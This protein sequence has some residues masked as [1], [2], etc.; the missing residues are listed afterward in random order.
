[1]KMHVLPGDSLIET[2]KKINIEGEIIVCRECLVDGDLSA[3]NL[4]DFW[5]VRENYL[6][7]E[8]GETRK[9]DGF[10]S[11]SVKGEFEKLL[12][13]P[14]KAEINLWFEYELFCQVNM[15]FCLSLLQDSDTE[16]YRV[17]P[18]LRNSEDLWKGFGGLSESDLQKCFDVRKK[19]SY[20]DL[21]LGA[22]LWKAFQD[23]D[24]NELQKLS[25]TE[26]EC[27][28]YLEEVCEAAIEKENRPKETVQKIMADGESDF[29]K[30]L[31]KFNETEGVYGFGDLQVKK[32]YD[33]CQNRLR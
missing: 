21:K 8:Y 31:R 10:Y 14:P 19:L 27:S 22:N 30:V 2:F 28:P 20:E 3:E 11:Q 25:K 24:F 7:N 15:W 5:R 9:P 29:G 1:M 32:I 12:D 16:I 4:E 6:S 33:E 26:S 18:V 13:A 23:E 17:E